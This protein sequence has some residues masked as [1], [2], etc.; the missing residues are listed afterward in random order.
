MKQKILSSL[1]ALLL[2]GCVSAPTT[3]SAEQVDIDKAT[4]ILGKSVA[5]DTVAGRGKVPAYAEYLAGELE[6]GGFAKEDI[7]I[8]PLGETA[9]LIA[10]YHGKTPG[11]PIL[12]NAHMDVV[13]ANP[14]DWERA[15]F[16]METDGTYY[17]G[18]GVLDDKYGLTMLVT[19]LL[20]LKRE[21]FEPENDIVLIL[22]GDE[23]TAQKTAETIA[24]LYRNARYVLNADGG[25]GT[26]NE[27]GTYAFYSLQAGEKTYADFKI[28][29]TNPGG[30]S[31][32]PT[33]HNAIVDMA[34]VLERIGAY[35]FPVQTSELTLAFFAET[36]KRTEGD[37]GE[38]MARFAADPTDMAAT[39]R[40]GQESEFVG[41]TRTTCVP[42]EITGGH[43]PNALP[44]SVVANIN[45]R[46]F[47]G[48]PPR[49]V[50]AKLQELAGDGAEVTFPEEFPQSETSPLHPEIMAALRKAV[51]AQAPGLPIIPSMSAGTTDGLFFRK[52]GIDTYGVTG[53]F[54][55]PS[56]EYA[57]GLNERVPVDS[58]PGAL[59]HWYV[60]ITELSK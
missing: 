9:T 21:G 55:K 47:P 6:A 46:I 53:I 20:R 23:E 17:Y 60:L 59:D 40:I 14:A 58:I 2:V 37:L 13:E 54:M 18:R 49:E 52:E 35:K 32:R 34:S 44:Q 42:T 43:A 50:M 56:D 57:H 36:A 16:T 24:P 19:T 30:H 12:L 31:S 7:E 15:P 5:F 28:T 22:T 25:G 38:A 48:I 33:A 39:D 45:C 3:A 4:E 29:I 51:D 26:L 1:A 10:T 27:D 8:V 41:I 11:S